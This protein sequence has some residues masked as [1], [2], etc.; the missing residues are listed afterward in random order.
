[1]GAET[2][3][4]RGIRRRNAARAAIFGGVTGIL[5]GVVAGAACMLIITGAAKAAGGADTAGAPAE[6]PGAAVSAA[7]AAS[8]SPM[9]SVPPS[10]SPSPALPAEPLTAEDGLLTLVNAA[11]TVPAGYTVALTELKN[12]QA[13]AT[14]CYPDLQRMMDDCRAAGNEPLIC[15]S[16]RSAAA[17]SALFENKVAELTAGGL[18]RAAAEEAAARSV[19][20]PGT[21]EHQL[22]LAV[23]IVD[24][25]YQVLDE[26]QEAT[27]TQ[28]WLMA[29]SWRYGFIH[30]YPSD[31][32]SVT[33][34]IYEPWHYRYVGMEA[35][36]AIHAA[37]VC[38]EEYLGG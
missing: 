11:N 29:N 21:S 3:A 27:A 38:L 9:A 10:A 28:V 26:T 4:R 1:M 35:A 19:A 23:D 22:G 15:S 17:Q 2:M 37:G 16:Y 32:S 8:A 30:R 31:K 5:L 12:G 14:A 33:G 20:A 34:V 36:A 13:V 24:M 7:P 6:S 25:S 18:E